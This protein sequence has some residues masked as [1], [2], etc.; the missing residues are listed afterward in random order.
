VSTITICLPEE[1]LAFLRA[2]SQLRGTSAEEL[3]ARQTHNLRTH[4]QQPLHP[5]VMAATD[6]IMPVQN[7]EQEHRD[8]L[9]GKHA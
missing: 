2:Y 9:D 4:L 8:Y 5:D 3:L 7:G 1:D 6:V